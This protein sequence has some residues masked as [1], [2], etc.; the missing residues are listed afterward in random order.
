MSEAKRFFNELKSIY[1]GNAWH[2]PALK[3]VLDGVK[4]SEAK[5]KAIE[6]AH[7]IWE[8]VLHIRGWNN[9]FLSALEGKYLD[10]PEDGD[11]P[12][13]VDTSEEAWKKVLSELDEDYEKLLIVIS[14]LTEEALNKKIAGKDYNVRLWLRGTVNH[15]LY[16][17]G[18]IALLKKVIGIGK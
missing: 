18:Q 10:S 14:G 1:S 17:T 15:N 12:E 6:N 3:E 2:G 11:F 13:I 4:A 5:L 8:I 9:V 7:S 16:H